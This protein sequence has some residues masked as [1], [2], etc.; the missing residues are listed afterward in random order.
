MDK[1]SSP[2]SSSFPASYQRDHDQQQRNDVQSEGNAA[3][4]DC[5]ARQQLDGHPATTNRAGATAPSDEHSTTNSNT[6]FLPSNEWLQH[7]YLDGTAATF[8]AS[9]T[10]VQAERV[11]PPRDTMQKILNTI[12]IAENILSRHAGTGLSDDTST[13]SD[14]QNHNNEAS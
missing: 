7:Y 9:P 13:T 8:Q 6:P 2:S 4:R 11:N 5:T 10:V 14:N 1:P 3:N 12:E